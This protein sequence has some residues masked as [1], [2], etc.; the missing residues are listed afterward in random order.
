MDVGVAIEPI[1][2]SDAEPDIE[3]A[4]D[5]AFEGEAQDP[6]GEDFEEAAEEAFEQQDE[7]QDP[8][9]DE[10]KAVE[11]AF[12]QLDDEAQDPEGDEDEGFE[13]AFEDEEAPVAGELGQCDRFL[14]VTGSQFGDDPAIFASVASA[15]AD[16]DSSE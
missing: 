12:E 15:G 1:E 5:G 2:V 13:K 11:K 8:V 7:A 3:M 9:G 10:L 4:L 14:G 6:E 16:E